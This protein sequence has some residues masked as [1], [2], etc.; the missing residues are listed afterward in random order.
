MGVQRRHSRGRRIAACEESGGPPRHSHGGRDEAGS[1]LILALIFLI[2]VGG[3][4]GSLATWATNDLN[5]TAKFTSART[6]Q[7]AVSSA[8][9]TAIQN[10]RYAPLFSTQLLTSAS[11]P[12]Y[13]WG[14]GPLSEVSVDNQLVSVWCS[15]TFALA[16]SATRTVT[17]QACP[18]TAAVANDSPSAL[19]AA[20][21][22]SPMLQAV[23]VFDDYPPGFS[24]PNNGQ[25]AVYC[26]TGISIT[27]WVWSG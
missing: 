19:E 13:C 20:C 5:N 25:C 14:S 2:V 7:Y 4:V 18:V 24:A 22:A 26:G 16:T 27:S 3:L 12:S 9:N 8:A 15:T 23:A 21:V 17:V 1:A 11:S 6:L 10:I